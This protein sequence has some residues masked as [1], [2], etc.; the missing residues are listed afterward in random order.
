MDLNYSPEDVAYRKQVRA[1][2]E[3]NS[4]H[5][6]GA[7]EI[8]VTYIVDAGGRLWIADRHSEHVACADGGEV[9]AAGELV[10][11]C[12]KKGIEVVGA[13][14]Q[15]TGYCPEP[16]CWGTLAD[17]LKRLGLQGPPDFT[18]SFT[19]RRCPACHDI[20][21][22]K[23]EVTAAIDTKK[24]GLADAALNAKLARET[25]D[26][27]LPARPEYEGRIHPISQTIDEII[28]IFGEMGFS[29]AEGRISRT[30]S[31]TSPPST[32]RPIIR[33]VRCRTRSIC[34]SA[35]MA[36]RWFCAR[37]PRRCRSAPC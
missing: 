3:Q 22:V 13:S 33:R 19:F 9:Q 34:R 29:V 5:D 37:I 10:F 21:V 15:S 24:A 28:A 20:N 23:D 25:I 4:S 35:P 30:T 6:R 14:N 17:E 8:S 26:L 31:T 36:A 27:T 12:G 18:A 1:W 11:E 16:S 7:G 32:S 2:L